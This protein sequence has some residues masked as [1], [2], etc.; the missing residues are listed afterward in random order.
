M[1]QLGVILYMFLVG[2]D[3]DPANLRGRAHATVAISHAGIVVPSLLGAVLALG[4]SPGLAGP[5]VW[6]TRRRRVAARPRVLSAA[7]LCYSE[8][9]R[10][11]RHAPMTGDT[12]V[13]DRF[14]TS[15]TLLDRVRDRDQDAWQRLIGL[16]GPLVLAWCRHW[17]VT[18]P[19]A[20]DVA[21]EVYQAVAAGLEHFRRDRP[22]DTFRGWLKGV[23]R[24]KL[25]DHLRRRQNVPAAA[26]GTD[27]HLHLQQLADPDTDLPEDSAADLSALYHRALELVRGEFEPKTW[28]AFWR[29]TVDGLPTANVATE[30]G[31]SNA[32]VRMAKSRVLRRLREEVGDLI[33]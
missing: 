18:G 27:A 11:A 25:L 14:P 17:G 2:V 9:G 13:A 32:A 5:G 3:L 6:F 20:E 33:E 28:Q 7:A 12:A 26:G 16:Y 10:S 21:Q 22:G 1:A 4:L 24:H 19:D 29:V 23:T 8:S 15:P 30:L 31:L